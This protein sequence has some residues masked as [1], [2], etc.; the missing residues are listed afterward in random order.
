MNYKQEEA[1]ALSLPKTLLSHYI[2][3]RNAATILPPRKLLLG[4]FM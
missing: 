1:G 2:C 4:F 3:P